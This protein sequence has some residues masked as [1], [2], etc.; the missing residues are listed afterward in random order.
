[1]L[2]M[3]YLILL[4]AVALRTYQKYKMANILDKISLFYMLWSL[5]IR[6]KVVVSHRTYM[7]VLRKP[8]Y[9][10]LVIN[11]IDFAS[12]NNIHLLHST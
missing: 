3:L 10:I 6:A 11:V 8:V 1:M 4:R 12:S 7:Y 5:D 2:A 9:H